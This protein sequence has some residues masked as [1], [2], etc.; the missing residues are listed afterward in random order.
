[1]KTARYRISSKS[2]YE[3]GCKTYEG[4]VRFYEPWDENDIRTNNS[5]YKR[6]LFAERTGIQR[7]YAD[8]ALYDA[9]LIGREL[10]GKQGADNSEF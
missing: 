3:S 4:C 8:D 6:F 1:M 7:K 5:I 10:T 9:F 2:R